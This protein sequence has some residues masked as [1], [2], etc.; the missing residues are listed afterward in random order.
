VRE[1][2]NKASSCEYSFFHRNIYITFSI[3]LS[4][5]LM[6]RCSMEIKKLRLVE[7]SGGRGFFIPI[8]YMNDRMAGGLAVGK[9]YNLILEEVKEDGD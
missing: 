8:Q 5:D 4:I 9:H 2:E 7:V 1:K 6:V 3:E